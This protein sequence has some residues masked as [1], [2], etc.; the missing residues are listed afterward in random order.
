VPVEKALP[1]KA[2]VEDARRRGFAIT[3]RVTVT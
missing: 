3:E 2:V 1:G